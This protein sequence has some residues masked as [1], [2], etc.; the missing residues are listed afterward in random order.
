MDHWSKN[1]TIGYPDIYWGQS[2]ERFKNLSQ[3]FYDFLPRLI[4]AL[5]LERNYNKAKNVYT[6][7]EKVIEPL[8][9]E[10]GTTDDIS[11][12]NYLFAYY[13]PGPK[14]N[15]RNESNDDLY[16]IESEDGFVKIGRSNNPK[17]R[18][19]AIQSGNHKELSILK[20]FKNKGCYEPDIH[21]KFKDLCIRGEWFKMSD[22][23]KDFI[24]EKENDRLRN[25]KTAEI[26]K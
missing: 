21:K 15:W 12:I 23:I 1:I 18:L 8:Y 17:K 16:F 20:T 10:F 24:K 4:K 26:Q 9:D 2:E 5:Y 7:Y 11:I 6:E 25:R 3:Q 19:S 13:F 22:E 14:E